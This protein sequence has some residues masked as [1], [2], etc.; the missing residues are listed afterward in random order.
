MNVDDD[1]WPRTLL[2]ASLASGPVAFALVG[3]A[4]GR[5]VGGAPWPRPPASSW[6]R[7]TPEQ[8]KLAVHPFDGGDRQSFV[9]VPMARSGAPLKKLNAEQRKLAHALLKTGLSAGRLSARSPRSSSWRRC[10]PSWRRTRSGA[11][12]RCTTS[13]CSA[14]P[15]P[16]GTWGWKTEGHHL[17]FNFTVVKGTTIATTPTFMGANPAEVRERPAQGAPGAAGG[18]GSGARA[19]EVVRPSEARA[20]VV[21]D[22][23]AP[24]DILTT[25]KS[26]GRAAA[27]GGGRGGGR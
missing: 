27:A 23:K 10:W 7:W 14:S 17:S 12:R 20:K 15:R 22:A 16:S 9:Y 26:A 24:P 11:I 8:S 25:D 21:F 1:G 4:A 5:R 19:G 18:G 2:A 13:G 3:R 6:P